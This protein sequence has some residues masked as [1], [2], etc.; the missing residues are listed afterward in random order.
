MRWQTVLIDPDK[1]FYLPS[2]VSLRCDF[3]EGSIWEISDWGDKDEV[4]H[5]CE[6]LS[7]FGK[8]NPETPSENRLRMIRFRK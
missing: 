4:N 1:P 5:Q 8:V 7:V 6:D 3:C 2:N